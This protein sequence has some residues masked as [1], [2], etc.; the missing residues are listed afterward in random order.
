MMRSSIAGLSP[1]PMPASPRS[2]ML[3][4]TLS[5]SSRS[6][7]SSSPRI[8]LS[9]W[10][11]ISAASTRPRRLAD[12][13]VTVDVRLKGRGP[14]AAGTGRPSSAANAES[15]EGPHGAREPRGGPVPGLG[16]QAR[17]SAHDEYDAPGRRGNGHGLRQQLRGGEPGD[18]GGGARGQGVV[19]HSADLS[20][21]MSSARK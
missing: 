2:G 3:A 8:I 10:R 15:A 5:T 18:D 9:I 7:P 21:S 19:V 14:S 11:R 1:G 12:S 17:R 13:S 6:D 16:L 4:T 20:G